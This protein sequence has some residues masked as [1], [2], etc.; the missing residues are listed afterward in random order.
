MSESADDFKAKY[1]P[2]SSKWPKRTREEYQAKVH[3]AW[4]V[5]YELGKDKT[6]T[7]ARSSTQYARDCGCRNCMASLAATEMQ[8]ELTG[9]D[10]MSEKATR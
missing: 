2:D 7:N 10:H 1:T 6:C 9:Y 5:G 8:K 4:S 3:E